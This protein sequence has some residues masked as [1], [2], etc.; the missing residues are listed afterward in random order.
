MSENHPWRFMLSHVNEEIKRKL[1]LVRSREHFI[2]SLTSIFITIIS[3]MEARK[4]YRL[5]LF[6]RAKI[7]MFSLLMWEYEKGSVGNDNIL[8]LTRCRRLH[9]EGLEVD[10]KLLKQFIK[11]TDDEKMKKSLKWDS[12]D[13]KNPIKMRRLSLR[14]GER[15]A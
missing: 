2:S 13:R 11:K 8:A 12:E 14:K 15:H 3:F 4:L 1:V 5:P 10:K 6:I 7:K 9:D